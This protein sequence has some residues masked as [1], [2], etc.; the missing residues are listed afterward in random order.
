M[1]PSVPLYRDP[2]LEI[3]AMVLPPKILGQSENLE[4]SNFYDET[5][6]MT[7]IEMAKFNKG[8]IVAVGGRQISTTLPKYIYTVYTYIIISYTYLNMCIHICIYRWF[9][10]R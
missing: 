5:G 6:W 8:V 4:R 9:N 1:V 7:R 3:R 2:A 10:F